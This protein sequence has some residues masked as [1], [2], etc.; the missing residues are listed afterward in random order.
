MQSGYLNARCRDAGAL[1]REYGVWC[2]RM[3]LPMVW[4]G[5]RSPHSRFASVHLDLFT[6]PGELTVKGL[7][8]LIAVS[9]AVVPAQFASIASHGAVWD[10]VPTRAAP[11]FAQ[12]VFRVARRRGHFA[13]PEA[14]PADGV[15]S[16]VVEFPPPAVRLA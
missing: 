6:T 4:V 15:S 16:N 12:A 7:A 10:P 14:H 13:I 8:G 11:A 3:G 9:A 5:T 2:W 1:L